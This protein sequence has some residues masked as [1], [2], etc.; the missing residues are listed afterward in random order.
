MPMGWLALNCF[1]S[2]FD[3]QGVPRRSQIAIGMGFRSTRN[4]FVF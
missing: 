1:A 3:N 4:S 2:I